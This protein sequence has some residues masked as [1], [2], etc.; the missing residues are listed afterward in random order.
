MLNDIPSNES[1]LN[2]VREGMNV[3]DS[4]GDQVGTVADVYMGSDGVTSDPRPDFPAE[5]SFVEDLAELFTGDDTI[6]D[7]LQRRMLQ[8]G[9]IR[10]DTAGLFRSDR[11]ILLD[12]ISGVSADGVRLNVR[13]DSLI[14]R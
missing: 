5:D 6:P 14:H 10:V 4:K 8:E 13:Q 9:Y 1:I 7:V 2:G 3:Y 11:F 12:Q